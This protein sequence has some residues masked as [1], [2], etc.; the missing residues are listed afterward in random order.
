MRSEDTK[1][2]LLP[3]QT[4]PEPSFPSQQLRHQRRRRHISDDIET[5]T[6]TLSTDWCTAIQRYIHPRTDR[7]LF[8]CPFVLR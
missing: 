6:I 5:T 1:L 2:L 7:S 4:E 8:H 3:T